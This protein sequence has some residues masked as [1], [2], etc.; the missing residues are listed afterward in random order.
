MTKGQIIELYGE[1]KFDKYMNS[2]DERPPILEFSDDR[3]PC[4]ETKYM[5]IPA[6][7]LPGAES[8]EDTQKRVEVYWADKIAP[9]LLSGKNSLVVSHRNTIK[10]LRNI[11]GDVD[12]KGLSA[13][14][15]PAGIPRIY[16]FN[17]KLQIVDKYYLADDEEVRNRTLKV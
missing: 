11:I 8:L 14:V 2:F 4:N 17:D 7:A 3:H 16:E 13:L 6:L 5:K 15:I 9:A 10:A 12:D 1:E